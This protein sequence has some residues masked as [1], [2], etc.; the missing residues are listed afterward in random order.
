MF[1]IKYDFLIV[2]MLFINFRK[3]YRTYLSCENIRNTTFTF[4]VSTVAGLRLFSVLKTHRIAV[5][6]LFQ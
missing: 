3:C 5:S 1:F 4:F 2:F 6:G